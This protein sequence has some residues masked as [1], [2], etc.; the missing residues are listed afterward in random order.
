MLRSRSLFACMGVFALMTA[1]TTTVPD[2][3]NADIKAVK[4]V[5]AAWVKDRNRRLQGHP[6]NC[7]CLKP[8]DSA[9]GIRQRG[10]T[11]YGHSVVHCTLG[12]RTLGFRADLLEARRRGRTC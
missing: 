11:R 1:C 9:G 7:E 5:E 4:D 12:R 10:R 8:E 3:R 6:Q 2:T